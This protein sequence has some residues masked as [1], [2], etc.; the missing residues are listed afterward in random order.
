MVAPASWGVIL[1]TPRGSIIINISGL[2]SKARNW[3]FTINNYTEDDLKSIPDWD[4]KAVA[5]SQETGE[6]GTP[7]LQ[8]FV[9]FQNAVRLSTMK[10]L[11]PR[12]HWEIMRGSIQDNERYCSKQEQLTVYGKWIVATGAHGGAPR[13]RRIPFLYTHLP[14]REAGVPRPAHP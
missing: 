2:M 5:F 13:L 9:C 4:C 7:H 6:S 10:L 11:H 3:C 12:A 8:G 1:G 14:S